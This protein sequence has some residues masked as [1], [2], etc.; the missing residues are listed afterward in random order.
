MEYA[1]QDSEYTN[2]LWKTDVPKG[3][4]MSNGVQ[5]YAMEYKTIQHKTVQWSTK[6]CYGVMEYKTIQHKTVQWSTNVCY[7]ACYGVQK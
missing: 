2:E 1:R 6:A 4:H 3:V 7:G 5:K